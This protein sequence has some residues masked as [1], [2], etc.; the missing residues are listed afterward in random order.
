MSMK[1]PMR[2]DRF[3]S[4][5]TDYSRKQVKYL[6]YGKR[7]TLNDELV[8]LADTKINA[9]DKVCIDGELLG[10][11]SQRYFMLNKPVGFV[12]A[13]KDKEHLTVME[14]IDE[15]R[16]EQLS[17]AGRLDMDTSG[18]VLL[19]DDGQWLHRVISPKHDCAKV[20]LVETIEPLDERQIKK[21]EEGVFLKNDK[22]RTKPAKVEIIDEY[23]YRLSITEGRYHQVKRMFGAIGNKVESLHREQIG[24]IKLEQELQ[25]GEYRNLTQDEIDSVG[26]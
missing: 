14:F 21:L 9:N 15:P 5:S 17:V 25:P 2:L 8:R 4:Q 18:L 1:F 16:K 3:I 12:S 10:N 23:H 19:T 7:V 22:V 13:T 24:K 11:L 20:Y 6:L 26:L